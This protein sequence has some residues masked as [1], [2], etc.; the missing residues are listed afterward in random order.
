MRCFD[1]TPTA[2]DFHIKLTKFV[3][4]HSQWTFY[5]KN[6]FSPDQFSCNNNS[7]RCHV[8]SHFKVYTLPINEPDPVYITS[9]GNHGSYFEIQAKNGI[10]IN[11]MRLPF[12]NKV[13]GRYPWT[14]R[15]RV[16]TAPSAF[17]GA[18]EN[19]VDDE[20]SWTLV[21]DQEYYMRD[22]Y[23]CF[24]PTWQCRPC[25]D[26]PSVGCDDNPD[27]EPYS[28]GLERWMTLEF[29]QPVEVPSGS[30]QA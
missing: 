24:C 11:S 19:I 9:L 13:G 23:W 10:I 29:T 12:M 20:S 27:P 30:M 17:E 1:K 22:F 2:C 8:F 16:Y 21:H 5:S 18:F 4:N 28:C 26:Y 14:T 25:I 3:Y 6:M 7:Q 15:V